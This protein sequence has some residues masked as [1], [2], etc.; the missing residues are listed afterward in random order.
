MPVTILDKVPVTIVVL[1]VQ[2]TSAL[3]ATRDIFSKKCPRHA[4]DN[5][6]KSTRDTQKVLVTNLKKNCHAHFQMSRG[7]ETTAVCTIVS[8]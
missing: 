6:Q 4:L 3:M 5:S 2:N 7:K 8:L 1:R